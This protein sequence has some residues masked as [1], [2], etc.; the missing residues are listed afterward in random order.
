MQEGRER[1]I[2]MSKLVRLGWHHYRA[3]LA[4]AWADLGDPDG[5]L[6]GAPFQHTDPYLQEAKRR[7][8]K[9]ARTIGELERPSALDFSPPADAICWDL[10]CGGDPA[11]NARWFRAL[12][13]RV[14]AKIPSCQLAVVYS[15][16]SGL[17]SVEKYGC[18]FGLLHRE[19]R[20]WWG[21][22]RPLP[23]ACVGGIRGSLPA[24][25]LRGMPGACP[26][27]HS[28]ATPPDWNAPGVEQALREQ[29]RDRLAWVRRWPAGG[30]LCLVRAVDGPDGARWG[31]WDSLYTRIIG[32]EI[33]ANAQ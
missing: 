30:G 1:V 22:P 8:F 3:C 28:I 12:F 4:G 20:K 24:E 27:L 18:D 15:G 16:Y 9:I 31:K 13:V 23:V 26:V 25:A 5:Q 32:E 21:W 11:T 2:S 10:E 7:G 33:A 6:L 29:V 19:F 14:Q 17:G